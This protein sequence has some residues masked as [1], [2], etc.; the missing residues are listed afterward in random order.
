[1]PDPRLLVIERVAS[2]KSGRDPVVVVGAAGAGLFAAY[3]LAREGVPVHVYERTEN[4]QP[5]PRT[6]IVTPEMERVLGFSAGHAVLNRV[7][8]LELVAGDR[9]VPIKL[10]EPDLIIERANLVQLLAH[11]AEQAGAQL[12]MGSTFERFETD[13]RTT[14]ARFRR[15]GTDRVDQV[16]AGAVIGADGVRSQVARCMGYPAQPTVT[17]IQAQ[18]RLPQCADPGVGK[19]WFAPRETPYFYWLCPESSESA[20]VGLVDVTQRDAR[21]KLDRFLSRHHFEPLGYQGALVPLFQPSVSPVRRLGKT[22]ILMLGDAAGQ[23]KVTT[24]GG[25]VSGLLAAHAAARSLAKDT[26][27]TRELRGVDRELRLHWAIRKVM[28]HMRDQEYDLVLH[29]LSGK[30]ARLLEIHNR[31]R[32]VPSIWPIMTAEP[33]LSLLM[34]Q[35]FWRGWARA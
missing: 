10:D 15:R 16:A 11:K 1:V 34:A 28:S 18:V 2:F 4:L 9:S 13:G 8:T 17:V 27:Y 5:K 30:V 3:L 7:H 26:S 14:W 35:V 22:N 12:H 24:V 21:P 23:V 20:T 29:L 31:D 33:R 25:T 32:L 6:L 19:V